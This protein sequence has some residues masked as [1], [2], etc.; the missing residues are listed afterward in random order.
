MTCVGYE[1]EFV[2]VLVRNVPRW[3]IFDK[4]LKAKRRALK[5]RGKGKAKQAATVVAQA[6]EMQGAPRPAEDGAPAI[7]PGREVQPPAATAAHD[8][9]SAGTDLTWGEATQAAGFRHRREGLAYRLTWRRWR[10]GVA[11][12]KRV[13]PDAR[14]LPLRRRLV[15]RT[16]AGIARWSHRLAW[17][18]ARTGAPGLYLRWARP[19]LAFYRALA[20]S[21]GRLGGWIDRVLPDARRQ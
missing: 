9:H 8:S 4:E 1:A 13:A 7:E 12:R 18:S 11:K 6:F 17:L 5:A 21:H 3:V 2:D 19:V 16:R 20:W 14:A 15:Y 10:G